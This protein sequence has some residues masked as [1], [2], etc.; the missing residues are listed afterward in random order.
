M[1]WNLTR[2]TRPPLETGREWTRPAAF[3]QRLKRAWTKNDERLL[4]FRSR[5]T[6][7]YAL[8]S[9]APDG[10]TDS[11]PAVCLFVSSSGSD[12]SLPFGGHQM[13]AQCPG[14]SRVG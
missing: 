8:W 12:F 4:S 5:R 1:A 7:K 10:E 14:K 13:A 2:H 9:K 11:P 6:M 3:G